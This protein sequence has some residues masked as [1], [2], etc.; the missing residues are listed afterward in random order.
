[1]VSNRLTALVTGGASGIGEAT[2]RKL[3]SRGTSIVL[4]DANEVLAEEKGRDIE[5]E[6]DVPLRIL[7]VSLDLDYAAN[8]AGYVRVFGRKR[9]AFPP[10]S[11]TVNTQ[12]LWL[13][14]KYQALQ[15]RKK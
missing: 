10:S 6:F 3:A 14:Q 13:C 9:R 12:G 5:K 4:T 15:M 7:L 2:A 1:M 8:C 11:S